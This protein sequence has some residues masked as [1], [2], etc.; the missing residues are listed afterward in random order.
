[1]PY[2]TDQKNQAARAIMKHL[3]GLNFR[4]AR[5][6]V[7]AEQGHN[8]NIFGVR[9]NGVLQKYSSFDEGA[10]AAANRIK[11]SSYY[12]K[13]REAIANGTPE[14][15]AWAIVTSPWRLGPVGLVKVGGV[16]PW[17]LKIFRQQGALPVGLPTSTRRIAE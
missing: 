12:K 9:V 2:S 15:Q 1:M 6:W 17:Y 14:E 10:K 16:D 11:Y 7:V 3:P 4:V 5:A 13:V 8:Y